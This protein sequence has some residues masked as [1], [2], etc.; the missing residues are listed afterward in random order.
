[1][2][3]DSASSMV[4]LSII[5]DTRA[6]AASP[7]EEQPRNHLE[8]TRKETPRHLATKLHKNLW[9]L[10]TLK[11]W[12]PLA[13]PPI[14]GPAPG[15]GTQ[16]NSPRVCTHVQNAALRVA[17]EDITSQKK[18][19]SSRSQRRNSFT[20]P[21]MRGGRGWVHVMTDVRELRH[22][23]TINLSVRKP[24]SHPHHCSTHK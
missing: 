23:E 18:V 5:A 19:Y 8:T 17:C 10:P 24:R 11:L 13:S 16:G 22:F 9:A 7:L 14:A 3:S 21:A 4:V 12:T 6:R 15:E 20:V 1:M 2:A